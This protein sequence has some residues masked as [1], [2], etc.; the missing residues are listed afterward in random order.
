MPHS[1]ILA[2][3]RPDSEDIL[4]EIEGM[5]DEELDEEEE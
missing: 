3:V 5:L 1:A 2:L 4:N